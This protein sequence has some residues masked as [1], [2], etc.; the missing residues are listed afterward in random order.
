[1]KR[2]IFSLFAVTM[3]AVAGVSCSPSPGQGPE[4]TT[5]G[6]FG[7]AAEWRQ[8]IEQGRGDEAESIFFY[9]Y[10]GE[11]INFK[12]RPYLVGIKAASPADVQRLIA[13]PALRA[14]E[15][16]GVWIIAAVRRNETS[17]ADIRRMGGVVDVAHGLEYTDGSLHFLTDKIYLEFKAGDRPEAVLKKVGMLDKVISMEPV[18][19]SRN[20][21]NVSFGDALADVVATSVEL[22]ETR[23]FV[24]AEPA[25]L[26]TK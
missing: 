7:D 25:V 9:S 11:K 21:Y 6:G 3:V 19:Q 16:R 4:Q 15:W 17:L 20:G 8:I 22:Y 24:S 1:M 10:T 14:G 13:D 12:V 26:S 2:L 23:E 5:V 18:N